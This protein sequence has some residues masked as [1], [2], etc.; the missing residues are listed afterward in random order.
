MRGYSV[1]QNNTTNGFESHHHLHHLHH[2]LER[3][4]L[5]IGLTPG[6][7]NVVVKSAPF[8]GPIEVTVRGSHLVLSRRIA[9]RILVHV[10]ARA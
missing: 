7:P 3:R 1:N 2:R 6:T 4:L 8:H 9:H 10:H 5:D